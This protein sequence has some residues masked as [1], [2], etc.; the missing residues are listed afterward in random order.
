MKTNT[1]INIFS[2]VLDS[3]NF[4]QMDSH[5]PILSDTDGRGGNAKFLNMQSEVGD[6]NGRPSD[7]KVTHSAS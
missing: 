4:L 7:E 5:V 3:L 6:G 1:E 2:L